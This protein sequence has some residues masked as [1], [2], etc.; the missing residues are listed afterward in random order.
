MK[1][2]L[3]LLSVMV[4]VMFSLS[5]C[6]EKTALVV[7]QSEDQK[8]VYHLEDLPKGTIL[9]VAGPVVIRS[10][11]DLTVSFCPDE[12][13]KNCGGVQTFPAGNEALLKG[14]KTKTYVISIQVGEWQWSKEKFREVIIHVG[15][16]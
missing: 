4:A 1:K 8:A 10:D 13:G 7:N 11:Y 3:V 16:P 2:I 12:T 9:R 5:C 15:S 14:E 6:G